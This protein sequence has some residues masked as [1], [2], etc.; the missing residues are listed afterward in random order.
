MHRFERAIVNSGFMRPQDRIEINLAPA[1]N[2]AE[3]A[4]VEDIEVIPVA[5]LAQ[6][7]GRHNLRNPDPQSEN[8]EN[9][10]PSQA[11]EGRL[12]N[13]PEQ[14]GDPQL[15]LDERVPVRPTN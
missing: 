4:V 10:G 15:V 5:I 14:R 12:S 13:I 6:A 9:S 2:A 3:A 11:A 1:E 8:L 7:A